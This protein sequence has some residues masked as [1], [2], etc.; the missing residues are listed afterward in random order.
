MSVDYAIFS[1]AIHLLMYFSANRPNNFTAS[2]G[3]ICMASLEHDSVG[4]AA[5]TSE[6]NSD[7]NDDDGVG[8]WHTKEWAVLSSSRKRRHEGAPNRMATIR[9]MGTRTSCYCVWL[10]QL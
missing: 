3:S 2:L 5:T 8:L 10:R 4:S 9:F 7:D 1:T 6:E